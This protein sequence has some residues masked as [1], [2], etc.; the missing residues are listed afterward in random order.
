MNSKSWRN[1]WIIEW[2]KVRFIMVQNLFDTPFSIFVFIHT[3][4][5]GKSFLSPRNFWPDSIVEVLMLNLNF[6]RIW[7]IGFKL[8]SQLKFIMI[9]KHWFFEFLSSGLFEQ[10][11]G[12]SINFF[13]R[14]VRVRCGKSKL[15]KWY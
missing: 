3:A 11:E 10:L 7:K 12:K 13:R 1:S 2:R 9:D 4:A 15:L 6:L 5:P 8:F 14:W